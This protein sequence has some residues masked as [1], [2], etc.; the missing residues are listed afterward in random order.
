MAT[1]RFRSVCEKD[2]IKFETASIFILK[3]LDYSLLVYNHAKQIESEQSNC[4][5]VTYVMKQIT[6][7]FV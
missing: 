4:G 1:L 5:I 2:S 3:Q 7:D 6:N